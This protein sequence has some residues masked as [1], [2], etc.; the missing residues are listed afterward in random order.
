M[1]GTCENCR[2]Y[3]LPYCESNSGTCDNEESEYFDD[4][5]YRDETCDYFEEKDEF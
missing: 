4:L 1:G 2:F 3:K 5:V